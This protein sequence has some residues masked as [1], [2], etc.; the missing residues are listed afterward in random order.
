MVRDLKLGRERLWQLEPDRIDEARLALEA[1]GRAWEQALGRL[2]TWV[3]S[4]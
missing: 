1:L 4:E 2:K 3:E